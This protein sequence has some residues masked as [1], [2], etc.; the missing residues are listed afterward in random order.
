MGSLK[1]CGNGCV[2]TSLAYWSP[3]LLVLT[4]RDLP[5]LG[6]LFLSCSCGE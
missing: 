1:P 4:T 6:T 5:L 2:G 3:G